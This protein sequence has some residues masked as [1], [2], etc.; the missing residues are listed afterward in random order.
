[1]A[2]V[3]AQSDDPK[4]GVQADQPE[5]NCVRQY[6]GPVRCIHGRE[7]RKNAQYYVKKRH[8]LIHDSGQPQL[9]QQEFSDSLTDSWPLL[10]GRC[11]NCA[12]VLHEGKARHR[13]LQIFVQ[14]SVSALTTRDQRC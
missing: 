11:L 1:M 6:P 14:M 2:V 12:M 4:S 10:R 3:V 13:L 5:K 7:K 9:L 8:R